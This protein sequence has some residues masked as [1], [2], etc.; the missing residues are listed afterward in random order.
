MVFLDI[1]SFSDYL[2]DNSEDEALRML[3]I[4]IPEVLDII[5]DYGGVF[6]K[7]TGDGVLA[8]FG[9]GKS[10]TVAVRTILDFLAT[11]KWALANVINPQLQEKGIAPISIS[12]GATYGTTYLSRIGVKSGNQ[13]MNRLTAVSKIANTASR[14]E[15]KAG[16]NEYLVG[17][18]IEYY[19]QETSW[20]SWMEF[21][22]V[23]EYRWSP[24]SDSDERLFRIYDFVGEWNSTKTENLEP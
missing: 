5:R 18:R 6:E 10:D 19:S 1:N 4:F 14:L 15:E 21:R 7:N 24:K 17:P 9:A 13:Q 16:M 2:F 20:D 11:V 23:L 8:Y 12:C 22:E 3:N